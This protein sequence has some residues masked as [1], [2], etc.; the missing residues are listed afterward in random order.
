[1]YLQTE[2]TIK[3]PHILMPVLPGISKGQK[4]SMSSRNTKNIA[5]I[6]EKL[7]DVVIGRNKNDRSTE[8]AVVMRA[9]IT[10][11]NAAMITDKLYKNGWCRISTPPTRNGKDQRKVTSDE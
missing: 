6:G 11:G 3:N 9:A 8:E 5:G 10:A 7:I 1:M 4:S 2:E